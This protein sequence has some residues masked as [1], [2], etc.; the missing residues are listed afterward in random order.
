[1]WHKYDNMCVMK[2]KNCPQNL[3]KTPGTPQEFVDK[4]INR[5]SH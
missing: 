2:D 5:D 1:M 4:V 3:W